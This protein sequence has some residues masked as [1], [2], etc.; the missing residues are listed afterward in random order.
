MPGMPA[1]TRHDAR[2][3]GAARRDLSGP[4]SRSAA[5]LEQEGTLLAADGIR[6]PAPDVEASGIVAGHGAIEQD[7]LQALRVDGLRVRPPALE[8]ERH[9]V[10]ALA[11]LGD[12][13]DVPPA[14]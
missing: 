4:R 8:V 11:A 5:H 13:D 1:A 9:P 3:T 7:V 10:E 2:A 12:A 14:V 6:G